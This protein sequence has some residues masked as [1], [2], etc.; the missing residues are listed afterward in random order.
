MFDSVIGTSNG[1][2]YRDHA[3]EVTRLGLD[4][5]R[6]WAIHAWREGDAVT[7]L[8]GS[9]S[10]GIYRSTDSGETWNLA[11]EGL[12][13]TALRTIQPDPAGNGAILCGCEPGRAFR[14][15]DGGQSWTELSAITDLPTVDEWYLPYSPR[16]GALRNFYSPPGQPQRLLA[17]I[18]VGGL[19]DSA[20]GGATWK[21]L[22]IQPDDDV[23]YVT[24]HPERADLLFAALGWA[25]LDR[26]RSHDDEPKIGGV[27]RSDDGG[28]TWI[29]FFTDYT[30]AVIVPPTRTDLLLAAPSG[31]VGALG[32]IIVSDD[33]GANWQDASSGLESPMD[34][35]VETFLAAPD[36][37]I[38][39]ICSKGR[40]LQANPGEWQWQPVV[41]SAAGIEVESVA[42]LPS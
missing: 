15:T 3:G 23:H 34:D 36:G 37:S 35:M 5:E 30:R 32:R 21:L 12:T 40:L 6:I 13:A 38:W 28:A 33:L 14:S 20:D 25:S 22:E 16:A 8:A 39:A 19:L 41:P 4:G 11:N 26:E 7:I 1:V 10:N 31:R 2:W 24:G 17:S 27:A 29:K 18:E 42:F 9:Y